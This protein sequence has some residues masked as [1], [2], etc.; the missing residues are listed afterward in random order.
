MAKANHTNLVS[1]KP[2]SGSDSF[3]EGTQ[4]LAYAEYLAL[5]LAINEGDESNGLAAKHVIAGVAGALHV[6]ISD[7]HTLL[8]QADAEKTARS[9][10]VA[11]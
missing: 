10:G 4:R 1:V 11:P 6:L 3:D 5:Y 8:S 2:V 9:R 7:G